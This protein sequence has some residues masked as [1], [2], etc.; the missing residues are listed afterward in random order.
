MNELSIIISVFTIFILFFSLI[1]FLKKRKK[2]VNE[3]IYLYKL[4]FTVTK[5]QEYIRE[6]GCCLKKIK[7][8]L[9]TRRTTTLRVL[10][11]YNWLSLQI[12]ELLFLNNYRNGKPLLDSIYK[13]HRRTVIISYELREMHQKYSYFFQN[14]SSIEL[15]KIELSENINQLEKIIQKS[16]WDYND[17]ITKLNQFKLINFKK[18]P[19]HS[20]LL[21]ISTKMKSMSIRTKIK[22]WYIRREKFKELIKYSGYH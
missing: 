19:F 2:L 22:E 10:V 15:N 20:T 9:N 14:S 5:T 11:D 8:H 6:I 21:F 16:L 13:A 12:E 7:H 4:L 18:H 3:K 1:I 17:C